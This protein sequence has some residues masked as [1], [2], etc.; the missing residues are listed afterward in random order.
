VYCRIVNTTKQET[1]ASDVRE[2]KSF[3]ARLIGLMFKPGLG[4]EQGLIFYQASGI[5]TFFMRFNIDVIFLDKEFRVVRIVKNLGP[6]QGVFSAGSAVTIEFSS[7]NNNLKTTLV[8][9][10]IAIQPR[11]IS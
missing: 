4:R 7:R 6:W 10:T 8:G 2:A 11:L 3:L 5:H 9:D 1:L